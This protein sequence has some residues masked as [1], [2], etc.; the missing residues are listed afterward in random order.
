MNKGLL[1]KPS[2]ET[3]NFS[4]WVRNIES[5]GVDGMRKKEITPI[6]S[7]NSPSYNDDIISCIRKTINPKTN[8]DEDPCPSRL[9]TNPIH[10]LDCSGEQARERS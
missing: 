9:S 2:Y 8:E 5:C 3:Y 4:F 10:V 1:T 6:T 7:V